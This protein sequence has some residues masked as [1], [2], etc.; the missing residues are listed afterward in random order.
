MVGRA[1]LCFPTVLL[2]IESKP[3][4]TVKSYNYH[5]HSSPAGGLLYRRDQDGHVPRGFPR[6]VR[7]VFP[8]APTTV[9]AAVTHRRQRG[10]GHRRHGR[11]GPGRHG[12]H[13][14]ER[15]GHDKKP[16][17]RGAKAT[18]YL[19]SV[20]SI[21]EVHQ[22]VVPAATWWPRLCTKALVINNNKVI[23][24]AHKIFH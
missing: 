4:P 3:I 14:H 24:F 17:G 1:F 2:V 7:D 10:H 19:F 11:H 15:H 8:G 12:R 20:S 9:T 5:E 23:I 6:A 18:T 22:W 21:L 16:H 13:G